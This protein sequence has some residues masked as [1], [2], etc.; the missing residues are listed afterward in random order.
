MRFDQFVENWCMVYKPMHH[1]PGEAS[2]NKRFFFVDNYVSMTDF[3]TSIPNTSSPCVLME[4]NQEGMIKGGKE[5]PEYTLYFM[6]KTGTSKPDGR[7]AHAVKLEAKQHMLKFMSY[8]R[9]KMD[10]CRDLQH[11]DVEEVPYATIGPFYNGWY[12]VTITLTD[13]KA[14]NLCIDPNDYMELNGDEA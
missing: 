14:W 5:T 8:L 2:K 12:A 7:L 13:V 11:I 3:M 1:E 9:E 6:V 10:E 4:S